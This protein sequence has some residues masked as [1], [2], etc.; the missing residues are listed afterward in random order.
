MPSPFSTLS[1]NILGIVYMM[2][3]MIAGVVTSMVIKELSAV[4]TV[5]VLLALRF[6]FSIPPLGLAAWLVRG[7]SMFAIQRWDRLLM[8]ILVGHIGIIFWFL[9]VAHTSLGQATA[10]FQSSAIFV[11]ILSPLVLREKVGVYR[12]SAVLIGL[13][14][15]YLITNPL[16]GAVNI[17]SLYGVF[18][19]IAGALLVVVLR[20][21]GR[22][23]EPVSVAIWH[24]IVGAVVY[25]LAVIALLQT[26]LLA[27][28]V[29][30]NLVI[31][32]VLGVAAS[33][34]QIGFTSAYRHGE[35]AALVPIRYLSVPVASLLGWSIW[36]ETLSL[37]EIAGMVVVVFSCVFI[38]VR[39]Y[40][41][42]R[43][44]ARA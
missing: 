37:G 4:A 34:V 11:T 15:I 28:T 33:F 22:T 27:S 12:G 7:R 40:T 21:L 35:A 14:G 10:L 29:S 8:R 3:A 31:L 5:L 36:S 25:P 39:E 9:S 13:F 19:A 23:E 43:R 26:E 24:N 41:L 30:D 20:L 42:A 18:S 17:G 32:L 2:I 44:Q 1:G 16:S 38:S 6:V